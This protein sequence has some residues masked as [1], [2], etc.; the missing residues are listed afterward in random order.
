M[1]LPDL[2]LRHAEG[3]IRPGIEA[4]DRIVTHP[5]SVKPS[6][7]A[8]GAEVTGVDLSQPLAADVVA[9]IRKAWLEHHVLSFPDQRLSDDDFE[10]FALYFGRF[11]HDPFFR[12]IPGREHIAAVRREANDTSPIFA[13]VF[14][15]DWSFQA[16]PPA[17]TFLYSL[18]IPPVGGDTVFSNQHLALET[19]PPELRRKLEGKTAIH[20]AVMAYSPD[21]VYADAEKRGSMDIRISDEAYERQT[22]PL[23]RPHPETGVPGIFSA[24]FAYI[25]GFEGMADEE[26]LPLLMALREWQGREEFTYRHKWR[27]NMLVMWDN[28]SVLHRATGGYE[29]HR[30]ELHRITINA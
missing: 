17:A 13:E 11:G 6:G 30:R 7:Q 5:L 18:D 15:S 21:G 29:G 1:P 9:A 22:H 25:I 28:R 20:S 19:M 26:T 10:R 23:I 2:A 24:A 27:K 14:H 3:M 4:R 12:P 8:C 16:E